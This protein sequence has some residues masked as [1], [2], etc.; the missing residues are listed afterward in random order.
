MNLI[1]A[2]DSNWALGYQG[3]LLVRISADMKQFKEKTTGNIIVAGRK[4][5]E[6][7]PGGKPLPNRVNLV[8]SKNKSFFYEGVQVCSSVEEVLFR[9]KKM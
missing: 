6:S 8:L 7:F 3:Q 1:A 4:T 2:V 5:L 9:K